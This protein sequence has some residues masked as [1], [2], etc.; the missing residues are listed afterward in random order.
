MTKEELKTVIL[1]NVNLDRFRR[2]SMEQFIEETD[3]LSIDN[4]M[5]KYMEW[6]NSGKNKKVYEQVHNEVLDEYDAKIKTGINAISNNDYTPYNDPDTLKRFKIDRVRCNSTGLMG[7]ITDDG[8]EVAPCIFESVNIHLDGIIDVEFKGLECN[9]MFVHREAAESL[10]DKKEIL[11]YGKTGA[12]IIN[13]PKR[14]PLS[15]QLFN[16]LS[17]SN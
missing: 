5:E 11:L 10:E 13:A 16:L 9:L 6:V 7:I 17:K 12:L 2:A 1:S 8:K 14:N 4:F 15:K 3:N